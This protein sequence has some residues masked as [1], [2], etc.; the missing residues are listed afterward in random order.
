MLTL[1]LVRE[2]D[3]RQLS[4]IFI[5]CVHI[6]F[7]LYYTTSYVVSHDNYANTYNW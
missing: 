1:V 2:T 4:I 3:D 5:L 6:T 7:C